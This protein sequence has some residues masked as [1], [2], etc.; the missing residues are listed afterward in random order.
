MS[1]DH[2]PNLQVD[3]PPATASI[4]NDP[5]RSRPM[6]TLYIPYTSKSQSERNKSF[7]IR[8]GT[9][10]TGYRPGGYRNNRYT[11]SKTKPSILRRR[12]SQKAYPTQTQPQVVTYHYRKMAWRHQP[13]RTSS[14]TRA[15]TRKGMGNQMDKRIEKKQGGVNTAAKNV[16]RSQYVQRLNT[17]WSIWHNTKPEVRRRIRAGKERESQT[18]PQ[19]SISEEQ[20][21]YIECKKRGYRGLQRESCT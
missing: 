1:H 13:R 5:L 15:V 6:R 20:E 21:V 10:K 11:E 19:N 9:N 14:L 16:H 12:Y 18:N 2:C 17:C 3:Q 4:C 8:R 7:S